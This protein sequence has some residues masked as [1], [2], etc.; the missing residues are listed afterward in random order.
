MS[1]FELKITGLKEVQKSL[2]AFSQQLGDRVVRNALREGAKVVQKI[3]KSNAPVRTGRLKRSIVIR[4]SKINNGKRSE[5]IGV[6]LTVN[7]KKNGAYYGR[8]IED[9]WNTHGPRGEMRRMRRRRSIL[10]TDRVAGGSRKTQQG[11]TDV[12]GVKFMGRAFSSGKSAAV[13]QIIRAVEAGAEI[14]KRKTGLK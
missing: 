1:D 13:N 3:A 5:E 4:N 9:G 12:P 7:T 2:Y 10:F 14:V 11:R 8:F 6:Y